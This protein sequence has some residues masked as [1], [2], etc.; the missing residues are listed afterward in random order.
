MTEV[1]GGVRVGVLQQRTGRGERGEGE[2]RGR[3]RKT[4]TLGFTVDKLFYRPGTLLYGRVFVVFL[5]Q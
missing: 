2:G 1:W 5:M 4:M 3:E